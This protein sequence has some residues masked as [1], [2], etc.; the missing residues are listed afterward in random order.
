MVEF[1]VDRRGINGIRGGLSMNCTTIHG[2]FCWNEAAAAAA[3]AGEGGRGITVLA[4][5]VV[6]RT[7]LIT[8]LKYANDMI[9]RVEG[10][11][12]KEAVE[13]D[14]GRVLP[15]ASGHDGGSSTFAALNEKTANERSPACWRRGQTINHLAW[16][17]SPPLSASH[18]MCQDMLTMFK[19]FSLISTSGYCCTFFLLFIFSLFPS[20]RESFLFKLNLLNN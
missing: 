11:R 2:G 1:V 19:Y 4:N 12:H 10:V 9:R 3:A 14:R 17:I 5:S 6:S 7:A 18:Q 8:E 15:D 20:S 16:R 13:E